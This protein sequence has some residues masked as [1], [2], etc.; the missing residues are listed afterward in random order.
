MVK[1]RNRCWTVTGSRDYHE[2]DAVTFLSRCHG[3]TVTTPRIAVLGVYFLFAC[4]SCLRGFV[5]ATFGTMLDEPCSTLNSTQ[6]GALDTFAVGPA[7]VAVP[8]GWTP[9]YTT[10]QDLA[11][12]RIGVELDIWS[13]SKFK[14]SA[15]PPRNAIRCTITRRDTTIA[16]QVVRTAPNNYRVDVAWDPAINDRYFYIQM[17][18]GYV[19]QLKAMRG[20]IESVR[21]PVDSARA[22]RR[23]AGDAAAMNNWRQSS[24]A[25][26]LTT[27]ISAGDA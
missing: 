11:L 27:T 26:R 15:V 17:Q 2:S 5:P 18:T 25:G 6:D 9:R 13:G 10:P 8:R 23:G 1:L 24:P 20:I 21:F 22:S 14:F 16:I 4:A 7:R 19:Q 12:Q 3:V